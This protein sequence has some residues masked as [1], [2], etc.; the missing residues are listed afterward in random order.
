VTHAE[1]VSITRADVEIYGKVSFIL[2][3]SPNHSFNVNVDN[4]AKNGCSVAAG[5]L[6]KELENILKA[7]GRKVVGIHENSQF[8]LHFEFFGRRDEAN[9]C[10]MGYELGLEGNNPRNDKVGELLSQEYDYDNS[11]QLIEVKGIVHVDEVD[12]NDVLKKEIDVS[13]LAIFT[14]IEDLRTKFIPQMKE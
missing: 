4:H 14:T 11:Y 10:L 5:E 6:E 9:H 13:A 1:S 8:T 3:I 12:L 7:R 2:R